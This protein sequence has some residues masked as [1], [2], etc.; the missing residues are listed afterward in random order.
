MP[1]PGRDRALTTHRL[2][3]ERSTCRARQRRIEKAYCYR[4]AAGIPAI[5]IVSARIA[6]PAGLHR[7]HHTSKIGISRRSPRAPSILPRAAELRFE[8]PGRIGPS[9]HVICLKVVMAPGGNSMPV[10]R[11]LIGAVLASARRGAVPSH[12]PALKTDA[13]PAPPATFGGEFDGETRL[14]E[15]T[16]GTAARC[17]RHIR[18]TEHSQSAAGPGQRMPDPRAARR[19]GSKRAK[20]SAV[21]RERVPDRRATQEGLGFALRRPRPRPSRAR[22]RSEVNS[23]ARLARARNRSQS[24]RRARPRPTRPPSGIRTRRNSGCARIPKRWRGTSCGCA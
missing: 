21:A 7:L 13:S 3:L 14:P 1:R 18:H 24:R 6:L 17:R 12:R 19:K 10:P 23:A 8:L 2:P 16:G 20:R 4:K 5:P 9:D 15:G 22:P 11:C